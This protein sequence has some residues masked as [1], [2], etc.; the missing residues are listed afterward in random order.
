MG[1]GSHH[2]PSSGGF[3]WID[4]TDDNENSSVSSPI[5]D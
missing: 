3:G 4:R 1:F 5:V 2:V